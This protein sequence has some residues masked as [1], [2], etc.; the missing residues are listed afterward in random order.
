MF[1]SRR[2][3]LATSISAGAA[4]TLGGA[5]VEGEAASAGG[6]GKVTGKAEAFGL[7]EV[8]LLGG[9][10][11][12]ARGRD[13]EYLLSLEV[14]RFLHNFRV[15]AGLKPK[16]EIYGGWESVAM[17]ADIRC[18]GHSLGHYLTAC[19]MMFASTGE[20][21]FKERVDSIVA[22]LGECQA[23]GKTGLVCA[24]P[25]GGAIFDL[26]VSGKRFPGVPWYTM[27]KILAGLRDATLHAGNA[28]AKEVLVKLADWAGEVTKGMSDGAFQKM[29]NTEHGGMNEVLADV[30]GLTGEKKYLELAKRFCHQAVFG[31]LAEE[32]D[33][34]NG[35]HANTQIPKVIGFLRIYELTGEKEYL[36][37]A[38]FFWKTVVETRSFVT[39]GHGDNEHF[40]PTGDFA[41][42]ANSAKNMETCCTYNMLK[43]T[44]MLFALEPRGEYADYYERALLNNILA[45][46]DPDS[47]MVTYFQGTRAGYMKLYCTPIDS[48]WCCTG[49]GMENHAKHQDSIYFRGENALYVNLFIPSKVALKEQGATLMQ[50]TRFPEEAGTKLEWKGEKAVEMAVMIRHPSWCEAA[51]VKVNGEVAV[52]SEKPGTFM[53][54]KREWKDGDV[55]EVSLP[56][57]MRVVE[58][59]GV[60]GTVAF[61][62]GPVVLAGALGKEGIAAG[63]DITVNE[64]TIGQVLN[65]A[66][67]VPVIVGES[68]TIAGKVGQMGNEALTFA[69]AED[70]KNKDVRLIPYYKIAHERYAIYWKLGTA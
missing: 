26:A 32:R 66:F 59:P 36:T 28:A 50:T 7:G 57:G 18:H 38:A 6:V 23:A 53:E 19:A 46:Q 11:L 41:R 34:L 49:T 30:Y 10:F 61:V 45:S 64:R 20:G 15:N 33:V 12:R 27:H 54:V 58:M 39:G 51:V 55:V 8:E 3:F 67:E 42:H 22:E 62:Y 47:G 31:P 60:K 25:E 43:L 63:A 68:G 9:P 44:R 5:V 14:D 1:I 52:K 35:L 70:G 4:L 56:M 48:F 40:F 69:I 24:F 17:W 2:D 21:K 29:L 13:G 16:G 65:G 37:A